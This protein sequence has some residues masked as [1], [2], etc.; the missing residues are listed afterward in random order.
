VPIEASR[1]PCGGRFASEASLA[2][3]KGAGRPSYGVVEAPVTVEQIPGY[4]A[5][6]RL[7]SPYIRLD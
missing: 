1:L 2:A 4:E 7:Y 5:F 6:L 3:I